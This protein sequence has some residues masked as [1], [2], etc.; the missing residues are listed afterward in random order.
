MSD[1][2]A[3]KRVLVL[4]D[5]PILGFTLEDMLAFLGCGPVTIATRLQQAEDEVA[6]NEVDV[7]ILDVNIH[8]ERSYAIADLVA[9]KSIPYI[10]ASGYGDT[11]HPQA[12]R[13]IPTVT[14][15]YTVDE[16]ERALGEALAQAQS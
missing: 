9:S 6:R 7:A 11:E 10:F 12:H 14:K 13:A 8:G 3:G 4:E 1:L 2:L 5:E 15:P 16:I